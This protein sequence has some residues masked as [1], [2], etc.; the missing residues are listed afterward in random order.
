MKSISTTA[1]ILSL[2]TTLLVSGGC[3]S[4]G[5]DPVAFQSLPAEDVRYL[6][7]HEPGTLVI[8]TAEDWGAYWREHTTGYT[9]Q[10]AVPAIDF[11][12]SMLIAVHWGAGYS[13]CGSVTDTIRDITDQGLV[14]EVTVGGP[15][16]DLGDCLSLVY[17]I[18]VVQLG[19]DGRP[20]VFKGNVPR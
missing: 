14:L 9:P 3:D 7:V 10:P 8:R 19:R 1:V 17:P 20:V 18:Q 12:S 4:G 2:L 13:G 11:D 16:T 5:G 6:Q 15:P